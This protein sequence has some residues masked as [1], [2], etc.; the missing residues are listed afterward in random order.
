MTAT[1]RQPTHW[2]TSLPVQP[3]ATVAQFGEPATENLNWLLLRRLTDIP[4]NGKSLLTGSTAQKNQ[5]FQ[6]FRNYARQARTYWDAGNA[7][8]GSAAALPYY[9]GALN[10]A[11]A[12][13]LQSNP[14]VMMA[15]KVHHGLF[16][17]TTNTSSI[18][19]DQ[20]VVNGGVFPLLYT[21]RTG[22]PL[23]NGT[24]FRVP[25]LISMIPEI[26]ME[27]SELGGGRPTAAWAFYS[28][29]SNATEAW[30]VLAVPSGTL[31]DVHEP[32]TKAV[33]KD[34]EAVAT[35]DFL[36]WKEIFALSTRLRGDALDL[37]QARTTHSAPDGSGGLQPD[38]V[39]A[40]SAANAS[41]RKYMSP[42]INQ[43]AELFLTPSVRKSGPLVLPLD[44]VR[45]AA[46]FYLS[47][48][49]RYKP[50]ALDPITEGP[51]SWIMDSFVR[52]V[53]INLLSG[54]VMGIAQTPH[55]FESAGFRL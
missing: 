14:A 33:S 20:L 28:L 49:V 3:G 39:A 47:S 37:F 40:N 10:L 31:A 12:E 32:L 38:F 24:S 27:W 42:P 54:L 34:Y 9:Y 30:S 35:T 44:L 23:P 51:Q 2:I 13:L 4:A 22:E 8:N 41:L 45:Y 15:N 50:T 29:A 6:Y 11:K 53:P 26:S 36:R 43:R 1:F 25:N 46:L 21:K 5:A 7:T 18:R 17:K 16:Y 55:Y 52:E 48:L 19:S